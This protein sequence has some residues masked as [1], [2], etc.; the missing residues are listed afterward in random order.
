MAPPSAALEHASFD[1]VGG[2]KPFTSA[3]SDTDIPQSLLLAC[4]FAFIIYNITVFFDIGL[5]VLINFGTAVHQTIVDW[6]A[7]IRQKGFRAIL[8]AIITS[9]RNWIKATYRSNLHAHAFRTGLNRMI[10]KPGQHL[11]RTI[12]VD[13]VIVPGAGSLALI[14]GL[15]LDVSAPELR[16]YLESIL[17]I[18]YRSQPNANDTNYRA[19]MST[20]GMDGSSSSDTEDAPINTSIP[21]LWNGTCV[22]A[23]K[24]TA[25][26]SSAYGINTPNSD[27]SA[28]SASSIDFSLKNYA[29]GTESLALDDLPP[30]SS[31]QRRL[32]SRRID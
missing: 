24:G 14:R 16:R 13:T 27:A 2:V 29:S 21:A 7:V 32:S 6:V 30:A 1:G 10:S 17:F 26:T 25:E 23:K 28:L 9:S 22:R 8:F 5:A 18:Q 12:L 11:G 19:D 20:Y 4:L 31:L 15:P 3:A